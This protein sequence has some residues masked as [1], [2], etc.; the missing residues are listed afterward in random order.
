[1]EGSLMEQDNL[2][3]IT[4]IGGGP[5]GLFASFYGGLRQMKVKIIESMPQLGG[6]LT[7]L[8]PEKYIYDIPGFPKITGKDLVDTLKEQAAQFN[9]TIVLEQSVLNIDENDGVFALTSNT[10][11]IHYSKTILITGGAGA[12]EP[13]RLKLDNESRFENNC[14]HY[15][16]DDLNKFAGKKVAVFGGGDS[17]LDWA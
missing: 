12:F 9:P 13:R 8:Y 7:A 11:E 16:V 6:Q 14:L 4:I 1:M 3:D 10:G 2:F 5:A 17:A 15:F